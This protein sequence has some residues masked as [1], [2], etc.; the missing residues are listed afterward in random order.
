[1]RKRID[2]IDAVK[3]LAILCIAL[4]HFEKGV[5][6]DEV[7]AWI[8][9]FMITAFFFTSGWLQGMTKKCISVK[10]LARKR[11][12]QLGIPYFW[13]TIIILAFEVIWYLFGFIEPNIIFRDIYKSLTLHGIG[14]LWFL[15]V[16]LFGECIFCMLRNSKRPV[17]YSLL[18]LIFTVGIIYAYDLL[19]SPIKDVNNLHKMIDAPINVIV[20]TFRAWPVIAVGFVCSYY[21][22]KYLDKA[23]LWTILLGLGMLTISIILVVYP[24]QVGLLNVYLV[25]ILSAFSMMCLFSCISKMSINHFFTYW[26][27]NSLVLMCTHFSI[28]LEVFKALDMHALHHDTFTGP[29]TLVYFAMAILV[30]YPMVWLFNNKLAFMLGKTTR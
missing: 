8:G 25:N 5:F 9:L 15:P 7:N 30:T 2:Y 20:W 27:K 28:T 11:I 22:S 29:K 1:M 13:F 12:R 3:G 26:G 23:N 16:L 17:L 19:W 6:P 4:L 21:Y 24:I 10:D 18:L 14:T